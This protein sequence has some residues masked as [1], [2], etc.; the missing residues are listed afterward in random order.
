MKPSSKRSRIHP[1]PQFPVPA[2]VPVL[3]ATLG[4]TPAH[5]YGVSGTQG[6]H[7]AQV[8]VLRLCHFEKGSPAPGQR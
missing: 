7:R 1:L 3:N 6:A 2:S 4:L 5:I 8:L